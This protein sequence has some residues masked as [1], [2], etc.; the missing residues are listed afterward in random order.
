MFGNANRFGAMVKKGYPMVWRPS[1]VVFG[2]LSDRGGNTVQT[3]LI[4]DQDGVLH[5]LDYELITIGGDWQI[6]GVNLRKSN[7]GA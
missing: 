1:K 2:A 5:V 7:S 6:N 3:V 4:T